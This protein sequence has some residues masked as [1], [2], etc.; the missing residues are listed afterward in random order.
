MKKL[1]VIA[2]IFFSICFMLIEQ[3]SGF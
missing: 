2:S 3:T 1:F